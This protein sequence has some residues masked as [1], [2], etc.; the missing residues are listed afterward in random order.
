[1]EVKGLISYIGYDNRVDA[2]A[3]EATTEMQLL[4]LTVAKRIITVMYFLSS[5]NIH[6]LK[7][8]CLGREQMVLHIILHAFV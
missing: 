1:L 3:Y 8:E 4:Q 2:L 5:R 6:T 7:C